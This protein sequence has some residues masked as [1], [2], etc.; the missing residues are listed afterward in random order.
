[1]VI[2]PVLPMQARVQMLKG[3]AASPALVAP[4]RVPATVP[5]SYSAR[6][7]AVANPSSQARPVMACWDAAKGHCPRGPGCPYCLTDTRALAGWQGSSAAAPAAV[8]P[9]TAAALMAGRAVPAVTAQIARKFVTLSSFSEEWALLPQGSLVKNITDFLEVYG[10]V[11]MVKVSKDGPQR[12]FA[13]FS[14][15]VDAAKAVSAL[16]DPAA[17]AP[18]DIVS[19]L[20]AKAPGAPLAMVAPAS[21]AATQIRQEVLHI[22]E[23]PMPRRPEVEPI[24]EDCEVWVDPLPEATEL[25]AWLAAFGEVVDVF[26]LRDAQT[27]QFS[28]RGYVRFQ[29]HAAALACVETRAGSWSESE[30]GMSWQLR[31]RADPGRHSYPESILAGL[32]GKRG[33]EVAELRQA[34]G[35]RRLGFRGAG[36]AAA[37]R[38]G[39]VAQQQPPASRRL[40]IVAEGDEVALGKLRP[41]LARALEALHEH[42][43]TQLALGPEAAAEGDV[44]TEGEGGGGS[45]AVASR[46]SASVL[47]LAP[48]VLARLQESFVLPPGSLVVHIDEVEMPRRPQLAEP[49]WTDRE[50]WVLRTPDD[51]EMEEWHSVFGEVEEVYRLP[52]IEGKEPEEKGYVLFKDHHGAKVCV[53]AGIGTWSE[54]ERGLSWQYSRLT[55]KAVHAYPEP[56]LVF[57]L[58]NHAENIVEA[59]LATG[60]RTLRLHGEG[61]GERSV[62]SRLHFVAEGTD[63]QLARLREELSQRLAKYHDE[64]TSWFET[65]GKHWTEPH[66]RVR[67]AWGARGRRPGKAE[68]RGGQEV[69]RGGAVE[70]DAGRQPP[71]SKRAKPW[72]STLPALDVDGAI[73]GV[74]EEQDEHCGGS[75]PSNSSPSTAAAGAGA[76]WRG[77]TASDHRQHPPKQQ[78]KVG[79][80]AAPWVEKEQA[81]GGCGGNVNGRGPADVRRDDSSRSAGWARPRLPLPAPTT[82]P[83]APP[84]GLWTQ[85]EDGEEHRRRRRR[86]RRGQEGNRDERSRS[87]AD[88]MD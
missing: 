82:P 65:K 20:S 16:A 54:S 66:R 60:I 35:L 7:G 40:H 29:E 41:A 75:L 86:H 70:E 58:N 22:D 32:I 18:F 88:F 64:A 55:G 38:P 62:S 49:V 36:L 51:E 42:I 8:R 81:N 13:V 33:K 46:G 37:P 47:P 59:R 84:P 78:R 14:D 53:E 85:E 24:K 50:V 72:S 87:P 44:A 15:P 67:E 10:Q 6:P 56:M 4:T 74:E 12:A 3:K 34:C 57:W 26:R 28:D 76:G 68:E 9:V 1:M 21:A 19:G 79:P 73:D 23:L 25:K 27:G 11:S 2:T 30:R 31:D 45:G 17:G 48:E 39:E 80:S 43:R 5:F 52:A 63:D 77:G 83:R 69:A 71:W 61:I